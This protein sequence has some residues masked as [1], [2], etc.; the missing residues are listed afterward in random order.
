MS[1]FIAKFCNLIKDGSYQQR[2][3]YLN[4]QNKHSY[5]GELLWLV[6]HVRVIYNNHITYCDIIWHYKYTVGSLDL[7]VILNTRLYLTSGAN[8]KTK[9]WN[10]KIKIG[11]LHISFIS[12]WKDLNYP[13]LVY[14]YYVEF[15]FIIILKVISD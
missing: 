11:C 13:V 8:E 7:N 15:G 12:W 1:T 6:L 4:H 5:E 10:I 14:F 9:G 3:A 2:T